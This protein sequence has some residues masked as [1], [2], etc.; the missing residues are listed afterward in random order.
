MTKKSKE[1]IQMKKLTAI[2]LCG[3]MLFAAVACQSAPAGA[4]TAPAA[5]PEST[6]EQTGSSGVDRDAIAAKV[7]DRVITVGRVED[8]YNAFLNYYTYYGGTPP[9]SD[10]D[11]ES[12][13][14]TG[15]D[16]LISREVLL[17][18][19][20]QFGCDKLTEEQEAELKQQIKDEEDQ[21][22]DYYSQSAGTGLTGDELRQT[23]IDLFNQELLT[24]GNTEFGNFE[25][26]M[27]Y[28]D[29][30]YREPYIQENLEKY[31][32]DQVTVTDEQIR[33]KYDELCKD[34]KTT[35]EE[36]PKMYLTSEMEF[37]K[38]GTVPM[39]VVPEG[40][41]RIKILT[42]SPEDALGEEYSDLTTALES[43]EAEYGKLTLSGS[44]DK[45]RIKEIEDEYK[46]KKTQADTMMEEHYAEAK[47]AA[48]EAYAK[49]K[50]GS[51]FE[52]VFAEY[53][54]DDTYTKY[55]L[56][57]ERGYLIYLADD[58][59]FWETEIRDAAKALKEGEYSG[60]IQIEDEFH[61]VYMMGEE[62]P[63]VIP[64]E[65]AKAAAE[66]AALSS[67]Q[68]TVWQ[69][70]RKEWEDD[71]ELVTRYE[72]NYRMIGKAS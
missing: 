51:D 12:M 70:T 68:E 55:D 54:K 37:E 24:S 2:L 22:I 72:E 9:T 15:M 49:L 5:E 48:E 52:T 58:D 50:D 8:E 38:G 34:Q 19:A 28:V 26:Y 61:I 4:A 41:A 65:E 10:A 25:E 53:N 43:L 66:R 32:K 36:N 1:R 7:G 18:Q 17:Y 6:A 62:K 69:Q 44:G 21:L 29:N 16:E 33:A 11:I 27:E 67:V 45:D 46:E 31:I 56:I 3:L 57:K 23:A 14:D 42:L 64:Y 47:A 71:P 13:Q 60:I 59:G 40:Y 35:A 20:E 63:G 30:Y 39:V